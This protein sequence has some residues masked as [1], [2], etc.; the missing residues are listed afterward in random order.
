MEIQTKY[1]QQQRKEKTTWKMAQKKWR[2]CF[3]I[4]SSQC[5]GVKLD[6]YRFTIISLNGKSEEVHQNEPMMG[7]MKHGKYEM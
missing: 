3:V 7:K 5:N 2:R 6:D 4:E 1:Q